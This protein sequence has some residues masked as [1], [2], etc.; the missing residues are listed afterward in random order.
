MTSQVLLCRGLVP[1]FLCIGSVAPWK[2]LPNSLMSATAFDYSGL[3]DGSYMVI[4]GWLLP[5]LDLKVCGRDSA[6]SRGLVTPS[7]ESGLV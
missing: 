4:H 5:M 2:E 6:A 3:P 7:T 1:A